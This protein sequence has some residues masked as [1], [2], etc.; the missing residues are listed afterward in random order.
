MTIAARAGELVR[1][2]RESDKVVALT[3]AG[4]STDSGIPDFRSPASGLWAH[5]DPA[6]VA[7]IDGFRADPAG[8]YVFWRERFGALA[9]VEPNLTHRVLARLEA[10]SLLHAIVTQNIDGLHQLAGSRRV[11][12]VH[13]AWRRA[14]CTTCGTPHD[15]I[16]VLEELR[17]G[18][19]PTCDLCSGVIKPDVV[20]FGEPL[21][22]DFA[23]A[24]AIVDRCNLLLVLGTSL[25][26]W[27]V[28]GLAPRAHRAGG[29]V[30][31]VNRDKT[32]EDSDADLVIHGELR[33]VMQRVARELDLAR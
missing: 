15:T 19:I 6:R 14:R 8:F 11:L 33:E 28:A 30:V 10:R 2:I 5:S 9:K 12:E 27:P 18:E 29:R 26:V 7:S 16:R 23:E 32:S 21:A 22:P 13:G 4:V 31:I 20:L 17:E 1:W 3:G 24:E 25:E